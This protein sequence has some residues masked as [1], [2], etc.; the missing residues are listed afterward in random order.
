MFD[1]YRKQ[2]SCRGVLLRRIAALTAACFTTSLIAPP[3]GA[4]L[5][6]IPKLPGHTRKLAPIEMERIVGANVTCALNEAPGS[7]Y[8]WE[9]THNGANT[10]NGN[11]LTSLPIV[12]WN[13]RGGRLAVDFTL[14]HNSQGTHNAE[15]GPKWTHSYNLMI[16]E[17]P[18]Y[19]LGLYY[20]KM[21]WGNDLS[22][23]FSPNISTGDYSAPNGIHDT[24]VKTGSG[25]SAT[26]ELTTKDQTRYH[27]VT[28]DGVTWY[29]DTIKDRNN[30]TI[31]LTYSSGKVSSI[32]DGTGRTLSLGYTSGLLTSV[33]DPMSRVHTLGYTSGKLT[34]VT[35]PSLT[36]D[37]NTYTVQY[38]YNT[39]NCITSITD[40]RGKVWTY[41]YDA[42]DHTLLTETTPLNKTTSYSYTWNYTAIT[43][44]RSNSFRHYYG[45]G[46][47]LSSVRDASLNFEY[48]DYDSGKNRTEVTDRRGKVWTYT[49]DS[50]GNM[51]TATDPL[52]HTTTYTYTAKNDVDT[53]TTHLNKVTDYGYDT[54]G[55]LTS[56]TDPLNHTTTYTVNS[57]GQ[58][59]AVTDALNHATTFDYDTYGNRDEVTN[60]LSY[61]TTTAYDTLGRVTSVTDATSKS[62]TTT[63]DE[64]GRVKT[65]TTPGSRTTSF[66]YNAN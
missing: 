64:W 42:D 18:D 44:P 65:I 12:G 17:I 11:K 49:Y 25:T 56:V 16:V 63:Y 21:H 31:T 2:R 36:G 61:V 41:T 15:L 62:V 33:T 1:P 55:N 23:T 37:S 26:F 8:P 13:V 27:F 43:D 6:P 10:G 50:M 47:V 40:R 48:Y 20:P 4:A 59:T 53:V 38:G 14:Y 60:A 58:V 39:G 52:S 54:A 35:Y 7:T 51:L 57:Y 45:A 9:G 3:V 34:S 28:S 22:Y 66:S 19:G 30:N 24:L 46:G 32:S 5:T 29:C